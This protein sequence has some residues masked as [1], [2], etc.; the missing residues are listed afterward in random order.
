MTR[1]R[2]VFF[3]QQVNISLEDVCHEDQ[4]KAQELYHFAMNGKS[5]AV[6]AEHFPDMLQKVWCLWIQNRKHLLV[7]LSWGYTRYTSY[8]SLPL[9]CVLPCSWFCT[10]LCLPEWPP[11][12][13]PN[14]LRHFR[15][16]SECQ[17][18]LFII[19]FFVLYSVRLYEPILPSGVGC[20]WLKCN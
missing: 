20:M 13:K 4:P 18:K 11:T 9:L 14:W 8:T 17:V 19:L 5:F 2:N 15:G 12:R 7:C 16:W 6:I 1:H 3:L 10:G